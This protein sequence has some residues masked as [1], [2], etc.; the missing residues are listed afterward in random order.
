MFT[1]FQRFWRESV[2][3]YRLKDYHGEEIKGTF[4]Q[5]ELQKI[6]LQ[7]DKMWKIEKVIKTKGKGQ[8]KILYVKWLYWLSKFSSWVNAR[9]VEDI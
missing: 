7:D 4:Y 6:E 5:S 9:D 1:V 2:P 3:I 8:N